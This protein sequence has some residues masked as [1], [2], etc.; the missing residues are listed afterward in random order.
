MTYP[1]AF[2][3]KV[4]ATKDKFDLTFEETS[5][6]F[7]IPI[8]TLFRWQQKLKPCTTRNKPATKID[9]GTL[10]W[11]IQESP[12]DSQ[13]ERAQR[14][15]VTQQAISLVLKRLSITVKKNAARPQG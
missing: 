2:R 1:L 6:Q 10:A 7:D 14:F 4:F 3:E 11:D 13:W 5:Q 12:D 8:R 9:I 15:G